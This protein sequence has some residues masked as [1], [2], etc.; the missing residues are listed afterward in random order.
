MSEENRV[1]SKIMGTPVMQYKMGRGDRQRA[2]EENIGVQLLSQFDS[3]ADDDD[4]E[5]EALDRA[6][7]EHIIE[8]KGKATITDTGKWGPVLATRMSSRIVHDGK[9]I[10][11]KAKDLKKNKNLEKP[12]GMPHGYK[13]SFAILDNVSLMNK[14]KDSGISLGSDRTMVEKNIDA[15][16][17]L[18]T[19]RLVDFRDE[20]PDIFLP[21]SLDISQDILDDDVVQDSPDSDSSDIH[22]VDE[23]EEVSPWVEVFSK[24]SSSKRKL[25]FRSNGSRP[26]MEHK[27]S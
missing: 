20:N 16:K 8:G 25:V 27:R 6:S 18:E 23:V 17:H 7:V 12:K 19:D 21:A 13:N 15:I 4:E 5:E 9:Y 26:Y 11:E 2:P 14:A 22:Q 3:E 1:K 24:W 10:F